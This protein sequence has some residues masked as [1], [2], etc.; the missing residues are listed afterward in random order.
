MGLFI[1]PSASVLLGDLHNFPR[2]SIRL[3]WSLIQKEM[4]CRTKVPAYGEQKES[5]T[6]SNGIRDSQNAHKNME[7]TMTAASTQTW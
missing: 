1:F 7:L 5:Q 3:A 6:E 4:G 2:G